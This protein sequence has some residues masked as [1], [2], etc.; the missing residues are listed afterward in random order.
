MLAQRRQAGN[1]DPG[2]GTLKFLMVLDYVHALF[3]RKQTD[4]PGGIH[5]YPD[6][7][8]WQKRRPNDPRPLQPALSGRRVGLRRGRHRRR[9][10]PI[11]S[12]TPAPRGAV[13][14]GRS[15]LLH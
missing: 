3:P 4:D 7:S 10:A 5:R 6:T 1:I 14:G 8:G 9:I 2:M 15:G 11:A 13:V 12:A